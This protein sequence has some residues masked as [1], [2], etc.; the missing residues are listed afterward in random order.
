MK[1]GKGGGGSSA[2]AA[3]QVAEAA[4][5]AAPAV[6]TVAEDVDIFP[7]PAGAWDR[8][9]TAPTE[10]SFDALLTAAAAAASDDADLD[11]FVQTNRDMLDYRWLYRLTGELLRAQN[12][13]NEA[14]S[15]ELR[16][17]RDRIVKLSQRF[18]APLFKQIAEAEG[19]LG[20]VLGLY[21]VKQAP[22]AS[23]VVKAAGQTGT[24]VFAFWVV[25]VA[26]I[27]AWEAKLAV[28]SVVAL[29]KSKLAELQEVLGALEAQP[30]LLKTA[31]IEHLNPL[32][33]VPNQ[34]LPGAVHAE[35]TGALDATGL[36]KEE[37]QQLI[38]KLGCLSCQ[39]SRHSFQAYNPLVQ[40]SAALYDILLRG[41]H[42]APRPC[43][44]WAPRPWNVWAPLA[45]NVCNGR[46]AAPV[47]CG[48]CNG[49]HAAPRS[50]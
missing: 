26:A 48:A 6:V 31:Q 40:K 41:R 27:A 35:A 23:E 29:A 3:V 38:R 20:Q 44:V 15:T 10:D 16:E 13:G 12:T 36:G 9:R 25:I 28:P 18:D 1:G 14:R 32:L 39:A 50:V 5:D 4:A 21:A 46:H 2:A 43:H 24:Q 34:V 37:Q 45:W 19:R 49:R 30:Q 8:R 42:A 22:P 7:I 33:A 47:P 11:E 17:L